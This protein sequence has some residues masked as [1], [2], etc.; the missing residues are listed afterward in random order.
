MRTKFM[1]AVTILIV[2]VALLVS[3]F[4]DKPRTMAKMRSPDGR[5]EC[6]VRE[7][8]RARCSFTFSMTLE[9][10]GTDLPLSGT[11]FIFDND[12]NG[13]PAFQIA[14]TSNAVRVS[15]VWRGEVVGRVYEIDASHPDWKGQRW[16][17]FMLK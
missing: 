7:V 9:L 4:P 15:P 1:A 5:Y 8:N 10:A 17:Y 11:Q 6:V 13:E 2:V 14:W 3:I 16:E 12:S